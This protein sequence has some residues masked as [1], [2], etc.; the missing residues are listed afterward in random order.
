MVILVLIITLL[1]I[2]AASLIN[3]SSAAGDL[4]IQMYNSGT[5][6]STNSISPMIRLINQGS[7][8]ITLSTVAIRYYYTVDGDKAQ[9][10]WCDYAVMN[11]GNTVQTANV[12]GKFVKLG[13]AVSGADYYL[14]LGFNS[15]AGSLA[16]GSTLDIQS[17]FAKTDWT[18]YTQT[19]DYSF[20]STGT[21]YTDSGKVTVYVSGSLWWG[22]EPGGST[23]APT[24][25]PTPTVTTI[26][27]TPVITATPVRTATPARTATPRRTTTPG[28]TAT[29]RT[30]TA[31]PT[32]IITPTPTPTGIV[33][34]S[35]TPVPTATPTGI[36]SIPWNWAGIVGTGQSLAVGA[37]GNPAITTT[38]PYNNLKLSLGTLVVPPWNPNSTA[39]S[40]VP[41]V[42]PIRVYGIYNPPG[43]YPGNIFGETPHTA[44]ANQISS[45]VL[46]A[47]GANYIT[48]H[49]VVGETGQGIDCLRKNAVDTGSSGRAYAATLFE[50]QAIKRLAAAAGKTYGVGGII[51]THGEK[52]SGNTNYENELYQLWSDYNADIKA[53]TGQTQ[54]IPL[55][56]N[57]QNS[58]GTTGTSFSTLVQWK[59]GLDYPGKIICVGPK[60][61]YPYASDG[62]HLVQEGYRQLGEKH[63]EIYYE[64]VV[65]GR[66][67]QPLQPTSVVRTSTRVITVN[68]HVPVGPLTWDS[69]LPAPNQSTLTE[70]ANGK[71]FEVYTNSGSR[72]AISSVQISGSS[73]IITCSSDLPT[74][75]LKVGYAYTSGGTKRAN[76]TVRWGLLRDSD[77]FKGSNTGVALPNF[78]VSFEL[79][80]P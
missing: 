5:A 67:W 38:Q 4:K 70:W 28:R 32:P 41:L 69:T 16:A 19:G 64:T 71:G 25:T 3:V 43:P 42:E 6:A 9:S 36:V 34:P 72:I 49:T 62:V 39:L 13:T 15:A 27:P 51:I 45:L 46:S 31:T 63:G 17:R 48:V 44:M 55:F 78:C 74:S 52:D 22:I 24:A 50:V 58:C 14:E 53:I 76:G 18:N 75:Y 26:T 73:V 40:M 1:C 35:P 10:Y 54:N 77:P 12:T 79:D 7:A 33:T 8:A 47:S 59:A 57:Q 66:N 20:N 21:G 11:P 2:S 61:Q 80:V 56:T 30:S 23:S 29:P 37:E 68:F 65:L 60:Y